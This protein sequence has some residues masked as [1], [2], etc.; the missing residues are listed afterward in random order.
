M[1]FGGKINRGARIDTRRHRRIDPFG[2]Y[3]K[4]QAKLIGSRTSYQK[5]DYGKSRA[6]L[7]MEAL[8]GEVRSPDMTPVP[9]LS[10]AKLV[11]LYLPNRT[12]LAPAVLGD[13]ALDGSFPE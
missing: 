12:I 3:P 13:E 7:L 5:I 6:A 10:G 8:A 9:R 11:P 1:A 2:P 4:E